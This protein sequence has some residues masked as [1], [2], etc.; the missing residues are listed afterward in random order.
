MNW[1]QKLF[2][3]KALDDRISLCMRK[4][5]DWYVSW[6][7]EVGGDSVLSGEYGNGRTPEEAVI[8]H[9]ATVVD[10]LP[11]HKCLVIGAYTDNRRQVR[12]NGFMWIDIP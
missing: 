2:A 5:G 10:A 8:N 12:W 6:S 1:E 3:C 11:L 7:V 4:P 9:W